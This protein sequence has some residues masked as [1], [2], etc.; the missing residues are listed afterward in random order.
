MCLHNDLCINRHGD[1]R[2]AGLSRAA[3]EAAFPWARPEPGLFSSKYTPPSCHVAGPSPELGWYG[4]GFESARATERRITRLADWLEGLAHTLPPTHTVVF[5]THGDTMD[6]L[7]NLVFARCFAP[8]SSA[9]AALSS[10][11]AAA[12]GPEGEHAP[13]PGQPRPMDLHPKSNTSVSSLMWGPTPPGAQGHAQGALALEFFHRLD[14]LGPESGPD[15]LQRNYQWMGLA[16]TSPLDP[17]GFW[18]LRIARL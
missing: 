16:P 5:F 3:M 11:A 18:G 14:H 17:V 13:A 1:R 6:R 2:R 12:H 10:S 15:T 9:A 4:A 8:S 7:M